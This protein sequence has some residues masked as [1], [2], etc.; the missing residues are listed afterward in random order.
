MAQ[1]VRFA[2]L[3]TQHIE[4]SI[5]KDFLQEA[6]TPATMRA[7]RDRIR[8][9]ID[10]VFNRSTH[11]LSEVGRAWLT[12]QFFTRIQVGDQPIRD[13]IVVNEYK[14]P[15]LAYD[16]VRLLAGLFDGTVL[17][18]ELNDEYRNRNAS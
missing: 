10:G 7:I 17:A 2:E 16:D 8:T 4:H 3:L 5:R 12:N 6:L 1:Q 9:I 14:L 13:M 11:K 15:Q 18:A